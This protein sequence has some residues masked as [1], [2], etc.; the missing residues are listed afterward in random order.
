MPNTNR[1]S[2]NAGSNVKFLLGSQDALKKYI[3]AG[4]GH[5][6]AEN[7]TFYLTQ[8]THR[9]YV[10]NKD[11]Y[12]VPVNEGVSTVAT[13]E[14]LKK[15]TDPNPGEFYYVSGANILCV[16]S[17]SSDTHNGGWVQINSNT[18]T[19]IVGVNTE[20]TAASNVATI[21]QK[22][23]EATELNP[24]G[25]VNNALTDTFELACAGG[26]TLAVS[27]DRI[28]LTGVQNKQF[29]AS[30][31]SEDVGKVELEDTFSGKTAFNIKSKN[32]ATM[33]V[34]TDTTGDTL[35]LEVPDM[36]NTDATVTAYDGKDKT[37]FRISVADGSGTVGADLDPI[38]RV[39]ADS[40]QYE[41][42]KFKN[43]TVELPVYTK[44][45]IDDLQL[46]LN[47]MT[48]R[49]LVTTNGGTGSSK[50]DD[51]RTHS[52][53]VDV[54]I[55]DTYL[56]DEDVTWGVSPN[57]VTVTKGT[58][59]IAKGTEV[60]GVITGTID[61][62][63]VEATN[64]TD[65]TYKMDADTTNKVVRLRQ[66]QGVKDSTVGQF[67]VVDGTEITSSVSSVTNANGEAE[68][69]IKLDHASHVAN[70]P[71]VTTIDQ[72]KATKD[73]TTGAG[74][75]E[76][77]ITA[78]ESITTNAQGHVTDIQTRKFKLVDTNA[79]VGAMSTTA[80]VATAGTKSV[81]TLTDSITLTTG[82]GINLAAKT[83]AWKIESSSLAFSKNTN[84][85]LN[86]D[87][88]WGTF[89]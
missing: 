55:G 25:K 17:G 13:I 28:T 43:G 14:D 22:F 37:G 81:A 65:T 1:G 82:A 89:S 85:D 67:A 80:A 2:I 39:G 84:G 4:T 77:E 79:T 51:V 72:N 52:N 57:Q 15:I 68:I 27:G 21:S 70:R 46:K 5:V 42:A 88:V 32:A 29:N 60:N 12:A 47:A 66:H 83:N 34:H 59:A 8:D 16:Y 11:G 31:T 75:A 40:Q 61:W 63:F 35:V 76:T 64:D 19:Y 18:N 6:Q 24:S 23:T 69:T 71:T 10:G 87:I 3:N 7:G 26:I 36:S 78:I 86:I 48:Y 49:G 30:R 74:Y 20:I 44:K 54:S 73:P 41:Y 33:T 53:G 62:D 45:E 50:W 9:L 56:F 58:L 38:V